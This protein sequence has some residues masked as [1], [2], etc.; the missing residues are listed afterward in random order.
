[1]KAVISTLLGYDP[2]QE[3]TEGGVLGVCEAYYGCVEAQGRGSLHCHMMVWIASALNPDQIKARALANGGDA[4]FQRRLIA[5]L[6]DVI[7][8]HV[9]DDP[10]PELETP[11]DR[12]HPCATRGPGKDVAESDLEDAQA[13]DFHRLVKRCQMHS[14]THSC[15]KYWKGGAEPKTCRFDLSESNYTPI[16]IIDPE[17]GEI[18]LHFLHSL[19]NN[20]NETMLKA[21]RCN[22]D[23]KFIGS[24]P[25]AK[26]ILF[27]ITDYITKS[28]LQT[29]VAF[30]ALELAVAKLQDYDADTTQVAL[31]ARQLLQKC[32]YSMIAQQELSAPQV[33]SYILDLEDH[34]TSHK[35]KN[36]YWSSMEY[37]IDLEDPSPDCYTQVSQK[38]PESAGQEPEGE[39]A[40]HSDED[41]LGPDDDDCDARS[42]VSLHDEDDNAAILALEEDAPNIT[43]RL[44]TNGRMLPSAS[45]ARDYQQR[46]KLLERVCVWDFVAQSHKECIKRKLVAD[47]SEEFCVEGDPDGDD[48]IAPGLPDQD[49]PSNDSHASEGNLDF[50]WNPHLPFM[51]VRWS[52]PH[53][54]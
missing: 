15:W 38:S 54:P 2:K 41:A 8:N 5:Y 9:P 1:M 43:V 47:E 13:S 22:M 39:S 24:G 18:T 50:D 12:F 23:I 48:G 10:H 37:F 35:Y 40:E 51:V 21:I 6:D 11:L 49:E 34:F 26:P 42:V 3:N 27:Y 44:D 29:H 20:F 25:A 16:T 28:Q 33:M 46:G 31:R 52:F 32:A 7:T 30:A 14:H 19:V 45:Q 36:L 53:L 17:T 4:D